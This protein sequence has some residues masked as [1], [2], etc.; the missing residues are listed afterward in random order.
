MTENFILALVPR[1]A[2]LVLSLLAFAT[3]AL[4]AA[5][6]PPAPQVEIEEDVYA[7]EDAKNGAGP[8]WCSGSTCLVRVG[9]QLFASG[10]EVVKTAKPL[11]NCRWV[12]YTRATNGWQRVRYSPLSLTRE[13]CP[14]AVGADGQLFISTHPTLTNGTAGPSRPEMVAYQTG[15]IMAPRKSMTPE[16]AG[17]PAF[18]EHSYRSLAADGPRN[19][20]L[21][22]MHSTNHWAMHWSFM[23]ASGNWPARGEVL[24]PWGATY[25][26]PQP[27][28]IAYPNVLL[29]NREVHVCGVSDIVEPN[30]EWRAF[31]KELT[32]KDWDY[33]FRRLFY[34]HSH[35]IRSG[36]WQNWVEIASREA[37]C[38]WIM[39]GDLWLDDQGGVHLLWSE[40]A[41][42]ER[43]R[44]RFFPQAQQSHGIYYV[45]IR[46]DVVGA[47][48]TLA[49]AEEGLSSEIPSAPRFQITP[50][51]RIFVFYFVS[52]ADA[53]GK[54]VSENR[55]LEVLKDGTATAP[56]TVP[57]QRP[58]NSYF[59]ATPRGGSP[60]SYTLDLLG[61]TVANP[62]K[63]SYARIQLR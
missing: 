11:N 19:E 28:R 53:S 43:L 4:G 5:P 57:M 20:L 25:A 17:T 1:A 42:D 45:Q 49:V 51:G 6:A 55:L 10:L 14:V 9:D 47:R 27:I 60:T 33:D 56:V 38:G 3:P 2:S 22:L 50:D 34:V 52:G 40:R 62:Q 24:W 54:A 58:M 41:I 37:T 30:P 7:F 39:P 31:K 26:R 29:R 16:W 35:D 32:G 61:T 36:Q 8:M 15:D 46:Q 21:L 23:D 13:P 12:L 48:R 44:P 63:I 18:T 59:T